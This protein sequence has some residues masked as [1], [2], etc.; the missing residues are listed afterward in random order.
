[1]ADLTA[2]GIWSGATADRADPSAH[3]EVSTGWTGSIPAVQLPK[4]AAAQTVGDGA[5]GRILVIEGGYGAAGRRH[6]GRGAGSQAQV[7]SAMLA[8]V[9]PGTLLAAESVDAVHLP[10][11]TDPQSVL[12][13]LRAAALHPGP[14]LIHL[15]GHL[16]TDR[17]GEHLYLTLRDSKPATVRQDGL[18]WQALAAELQHRGELPTLVIADL[19]ADQAAWPLVQSAISPL[20]DGIPLWAVVSPDPE[21]IGTFS[22]A[23]IEVLHRGR[24]GG[25]ALLAPELLRDQV[26]SVVR[27][28]SIILHSHPT[29]RPFFRNTSRQINEAL[30]GAASGPRPAAVLVP[31][32]GQARMPKPRPGTPVVQLGKPAV[33]SAGVS[34]L[35]PGVPPTPR[36]VGPP[37]SL[38][39][40]G[41]HPVVSLDKQP[42]AVS[43]DKPGPAATP[44]PAPVDYRE[45]IGRIVRSAEA[46]EHDTAA[47]LALA[48]EESAVAAHGPVAAEVLQVRQVRA[49]IARLAGRLAQAAEVYREVALAL[50]RSHGA[51]HPETQQAATNAEACWRAVPDRTEAIRMAPEIIELRAHLPGP[52]GRK[53]RAAERHLKQLAAAAHG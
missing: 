19:S 33:A 22:R 27:N 10:G 41:Q 25:P 26:H 20:A 43:F 11:A 47:E 13:H 40:A 32:K 6:W 52:D 9:S 15:G 17:R 29:E 5:R 50:L 14:L 39:K 31:P 48:L 24:P 18:P 3:R 35:K 8:A 51:D 45:A 34:L 42:T 28:D 23:L 21:Q 53:L 12:A 7:L 16:V 49:H 2:G 46:G 36:R 30:P 37:V 38:L 44:D 4:P 1:M